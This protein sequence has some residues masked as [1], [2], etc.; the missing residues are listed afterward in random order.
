MPGRSA[1][2]VPDSL[3]HRLPAA[4]AEIACH[5]P[6]PVPRHIHAPRSLLHA[7]AGWPTSLS[8]VAR[9]THLACP[10][11]CRPRLTSP[12]RSSSR[13]S[14]ARPHRATRRHTFVVSVRLCRGIS[15]PR[16]IVFPALAP[17]L[18]GL[19]TSPLSSPTH[20]LSTPP[21]AKLVYMQIHCHPPPVAAPTARTMTRTL[22]AC[23][24]RAC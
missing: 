16:S 6:A 3:L 22:H 19:D 11:P 7:P 21:R 18:P 17:A 4:R 13:L 5:L 1:A 12:L 10:S 20:P 24:G 15:T 2:A 23:S 14:S 8:R 9:L